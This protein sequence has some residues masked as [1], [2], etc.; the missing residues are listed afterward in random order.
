MGV[1]VVIPTY[2]EAD[3][4]QPLVTQLFAL[5]IADLKVIIIDDGSPDGTGEIADQ[6]ALQNPG[7]MIVSHRPGKMGLGTAYISGFKI[8][9][10]SGADMIA[11]MDADF[12]HSPQVLPRLVEA[13]QTCD[14]VIGSRYV[15]GGSVDREWPAWR[16]SLSAFANFYARSILRMPI[17]DLTGG[18]RVWRRGALEGMPLHRIRSSGYAFIIETAYVAQLLGYQICEIPI[19]FAERSYGRSKMSLKIQLESA[20]RVIMMRREF[21]NLI[22]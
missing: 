16:K 8:A 4:L 5:P 20:L 21:Q 17:R 10:E 13:L 7:R 2:N 18:Y 19:Y 12:S 22:R 11:Q 3:N 15:V 6:L 9:L 14:L 1:T